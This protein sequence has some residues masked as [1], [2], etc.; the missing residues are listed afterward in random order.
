MISQMFDP[1]TGQMRP[2]VQ[3]ADNRADYPQPRYRLLID[4]K[5]IS[6]RLAPRLISLELTDKRGL[7]LDELTLKLSD[8]DGRLTLPPLGA[9]LQLALGWNDELIDK[10]SYLIEEIGHSGAPDQLSL[11]ARSA[12]VSKGFKTQRSQSYSDTTLGAVLQILAARQGIKLAVTPS[13]AATP[14][15]R[16]DQ[17]NESDANLLG[18][19][20]EQYGA[21][22][23]I[24]AGTLLFLANGGGKTT[25]GLALPHVILTRRDGDQHNYLLTNPHDGVRARY[26]DVDKAERTTVTAGDPKGGKL[27]DIRHTYANAVEAQ[28]SAD[29]QWKRLQSGTAT[30]SYQLALG[31]ADLIPELTYT[32]LGIKQEIDDIT[33]YGGDIKH[34]LNTSEGFTTQIN[35]LEMMQPFEP[36]LVEDVADDGIARYSGVLAYYRDP[37]TGQ[38]RT[39]SRGDP[40]R[41][42]KLANLYASQEAAIRAA[43]RE[44]ANIEKRQNP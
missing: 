16:L 20:G 18:R 15:L 5:D 31:R 12:D 34:S 19:L 25:S 28:K 22:A 32:L 9:T 4:G 33:W 1:A 30:L 23:T 36:D 17:A 37:A 43:E 42:R 2:L 41:P 29:A 6:A 8:H 44:W 21:V 38:E 7:E 40:R 27:F 26:Y 10:G 24:K 39:V 14:I 13:L 3:P 11:R 35:G